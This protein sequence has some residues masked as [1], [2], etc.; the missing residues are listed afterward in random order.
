ML[1]NAQKCYKSAVKMLSSLCQIDLPHNPWIDGSTH[2]TRSIGTSQISTA[3]DAPWLANATSAVWRTR[4]GLLPRL[5]MRYRG[6]VFAARTNVA[7]RPISWW[8]SG[9]PTRQRMEEHTCCQCVK[10]CDWTARAD[11]TTARMG[12][13][14]E[15]QGACTCAVCKDIEHVWF[16]AVPQMWLCNLQVCRTGPLYLM[17]TSNHWLYK[18]QQGDS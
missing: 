9:S 17:G 7:P 2:P 3:R 18:F 5:N 10:R 13:R 12:K 14:T 6:A 15:N 4:A 11:Q 8:F 1:P 16:T